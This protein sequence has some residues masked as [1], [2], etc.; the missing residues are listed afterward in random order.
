MSGPEAS[1][2]EPRY[3]WDT[4]RD[5]EIPRGTKLVLLGLGLLLGMVTVTFIVSIAAVVNARRR[6]ARRRPRNRKR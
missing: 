3:A 4:P 6:A 1:D 2:E 5:P